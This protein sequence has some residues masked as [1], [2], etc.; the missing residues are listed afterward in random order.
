MPGP[1]EKWGGEDRRPARG[2][3]GLLPTALA[4]AGRALAAESDRWFLWLPVFFSGGII[5]YF[6]LSDEPEP[7][8]AAALVLAAI[9]ICL[10]LRSAPLGLALAGAFLASLAALPRRS[11]VPR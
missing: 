3:G 7:R 6:A 8:V 1:G 10:A 5:V 11:S 4:A 9:G 2:R